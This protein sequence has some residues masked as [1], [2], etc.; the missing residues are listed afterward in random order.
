MGNWIESL[1]L[2]WMAV[3]VFALTILMTWVIYVVITRLAVGDWLRVL[4]GLS[5][6]MLPPLGIIFGLFVAFVASQVWSNNDRAREAVN[7]EASAL[8]SVVY[9]A[10]S[11][12][13]ES[14]ARLRALTQH[15]IQQTVTVEWPMMAK[16]SGSFSVTPVSLAEELQLVMSLSPQSPGQ[17]TA[18]REILAALENAI[19]ARRQRIIASRSSVNWV[20]WTA[21]LLQAGITLIAIAMVHCDNRRTAAIA[22]AIFSTGIA[23]SILLIASHDRPFHGELSVK[24]DLLQQIM[25]DE[26]ASQV[27]GDQAVLFHLTTLLRSARQVISDREELIE[28]H[29]PVSQLTGQDL[30]AQAKM[31][32]AAQTGHSFPVFDPTS[33]AGRMIQAET[34]AM[35]DVQDNFHPPA[36]GFKQWLP[37]IFAYQVAERFNQR[38]SEFAYMKLTAPAEL[39]RH[40]PNTPDAWEDEMIKTKFQSPGWKKGDFVE[41]EAMLNGRRAYRVMIP[42]YY[43]ASCLECHG[44]P[45]GA[46]DITGGKKEG[47]K[48]GDL[49]GAISAGIYL[50]Q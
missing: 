50:K 35:K 31:N 14:E 24:P 8:S 11:F 1:P 45:K 26:L 41:E 37:A 44:T 34:D 42:E 49:G 32:Y 10:A 16:R 29:A 38:E 40:A 33:A 36:T 2:A 9:L 4:K 25:Q 7:R 17:V 18:Q 39:V 48:L 13:G 21:V 27:N 46:I 5:P 28:Q 15:H 30:I 20:K 3:V 19:D 43:E 12:P 6:G 23:A 47:G 22:M